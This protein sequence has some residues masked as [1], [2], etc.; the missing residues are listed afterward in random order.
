MRPHLISL[1]DDYAKRG[2]E[3][4]F[5][6]WKGLRIQHWSYEQLAAT[7][8]QTSHE[9]AARGIGRGDRVLF[10]SENN[11][12]W[13]AAFFGCL[14]RGSV[15]VPLD[16]QST[17]DFAARVQQQVGAK[18][19]FA[20]SDLA[21]AQQLNLPLIAI[22]DLAKIVAHHPQTATPLPEISARDLV[23]IIFTSGTTA[24]PKGVR[25]THENFLANI[26]PIEAEIEKY[27][28]WEYIVHPIRFLSLVPLSHIFGQLM[29]IFVPLLLGGEIFFRDLF[30]PSE[31][32][33]VIRQHRIS[34]LVLVP[35]MLTALR[36][37]IERDFASDAFRM[38]L[39]RA[40]SM[41]ILR[42]WWIF[43]AIHRRF[44][45][46][47]WAFISGG[48]TLDEETEEFWRRLG[49]AVL[50]GY[51]MTET[52]SLISIPHPFKMARRSLGKALSGQEVKLDESGEILV[53]GPNVSPGYWGE[54]GTH[55]ID[56][57]GWLHTGDLGEM[58]AAGNL[59]FRGRKKDVIVLASGL[60]IF[61]EDIQSALDE[62]PEIRE[63]TV[64]ALEGSRGPEP[65]A[66]L[67]L[68][69]SHADEKAA[70]NRANQKLA[71]HQRIRRWIRWPHRDFPRT[72]A[73]GKILKRIVAE[74][75]KPFLAEQ[76]LITP[77]SR[78]STSFLLNQIAQISGRIP[79][80]V[81]TSTTLAGDLKLDSLGRIEL[82][83]ALEDRYQIELDEAAITSATTLGEIERI[84]E[85]G[86][87]Q[88]T[89]YPYPKWAQEWPVTWIRL[90]AL[91]LIILPITRLLCW[92]RVSGREHL[93]DLK[94]PV[95]F[96]AN[97]ITAVDPALILS[98]LPW[99]WRKRLAVA[100]IGERLRDWRTPRAGTK[101]LM[102]LQKRIQYWLVAALFNVFPL[103]QQSGFRH[104]FAYAGES[105]DR[106]YNVLVFPEGQLTRTGQMNPF[107]DGIGLLVRQ[108]E[109]SIVPIKI[110]GLF[111]LKERR[112]YFARPGQ[113]AVKF[114]T[115]ISFDREKDPTEIV[116]E[117]ER[118]VA[119][120]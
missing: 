97:H 25:L 71:E 53:R 100:M 44:G 75:V 72:T 4:A 66:V 13:V 3:T 86:D 9:L 70:I 77:T 52:A 17:V 113:V 48:A 37:R 109:V 54:S 83:S 21:I 28:T 67:I 102:R 42:R 63:S 104:S 82:L 22:D 14:L 103:P 119:E 31:T 84:I 115:A 105:L 110:E 118:R 46:K 76:A 2:S 16:R 15:V 34:V 79:N 50:Q 111:P 114:G 69:D 88:V 32:I 87:S 20:S 80:Q 68:K 33:R 55:T 64:I 51:G 94:G 65:L 74:E 11:P 61:P 73:T 96:V 45:W 117:L 60:K 23:E 12:E 120:L 90:V 57:E 92:T 78:P 99:H 98:A 58:D 89:P 106:G 6:Y 30:N 10:W 95:L 26:A 49:F 35:R 108:L 40:E 93:R 85:S 41:H 81:D 43:R 38:S 36:E 27:R 112:Q 29:G 62:Q 1:L 18:L 5:V 91:A 59:Y 19:I 56:A 107:M 101:G 39:D 7:A 116:H 8:A 47:F 24:E